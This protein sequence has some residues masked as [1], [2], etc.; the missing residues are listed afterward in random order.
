MGGGDFLRSGVTSETILPQ[1]GITDGS[2]PFGMG[3]HYN[4]E[5]YLDGTW[6]LTDR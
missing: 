5:S 6:H 1:L 4:N 3:P 2:A